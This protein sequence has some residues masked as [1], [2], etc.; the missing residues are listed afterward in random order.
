MLVNLRKLPLFVCLEE[1]EKKPQV[2]AL[3]EGVNVV[4]GCPGRLLDLA[5]EGNCDLSQVDYMV[6]DEADRMLDM[7]FEKAIRAIFARIPS[8]EHRQTAMFGATWPKSIQTIAAEFLTNPVRI[9]IG[10]AD[11]SANT[12]VEQIIEVIPEDGNKDTRL[13]Q[14]LNKYHKPTQEK[15]IVFGLQKYE[16]SRLEKCLNRS[17]FRCTSIHGNKSVP[18]RA[19]ALESF[20]KGD[21][22]ILIATDVAS[23]GLHIPKVAY[24]INYSFPLTVEDYVHRIGR[25]GRAGATGISHTFFTRRDK[26]L[27]G[28]LIGVLRNANQTVPQELISFQSGAKR[29]EPKLGKIDLNAG[30]SSH[31]TFDSDEE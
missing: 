28:E 9:T 11:L 15:V 18:Q 10:S 17:G 29:K 24:V 13:I 2:D 20:K 31:I 12:R 27:S 1:W 25:T 26:S 21:P 23:R 3:K 22:P 7:G 6:L 19:Q 8:K 16:A 4:V 14:L 5:Q 30:S